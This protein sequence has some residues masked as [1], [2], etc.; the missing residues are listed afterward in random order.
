MSPGTLYIVG[1]GLS[2][3][4]VSLRAIEVLRSCDHVFYEEYT[5]IPSEGSI[6]DIEAIVGKRFR[7]LSR[8]DLEDLSAKEI[9]E[10][11]SDGKIVCLASWG[12]PIAAT[13]H[14]YIATEV[15]SRGYGYSYIPGV[16]AVITALGYSGLM[17]Y[18]LGRV[19]TLVRP[20]S[21][22]EAR[23]I[24]ERIME[25]LGRGYHVLL[26]LE[27]DSEGGY[28]MRVDEAARILIEISR[29]LGHEIRDLFGVALAGLGSK[30]QAIC[31]SSLEDLSKTALE[32][33]PQ[34]LILVGSLYYTEKE[35]I[36]SM[37]RKH[38][39]CWNPI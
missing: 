12:D 18:R 33:I 5:S 20:R 22:D 34:M 19:M 23:G 32:P 31:Y 38:G 27:M 16:S 28:Y 17:V 24:Y 35:Y 30:N 13:T 39:K 29:S 3:G 37:V 2:P 36:D 15:I 8:R 14:I 26:L 1:L 7:R 21:A 10:R 6:G 25:T 11:L 9:L 4:L